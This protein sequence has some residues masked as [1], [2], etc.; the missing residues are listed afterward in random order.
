MVNKLKSSESGATAINTHLLGEL[1]DEIEDLTEMGNFQNIIWIWRKFSN[2][3][4]K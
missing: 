1:G 2:D 3:N 4:N